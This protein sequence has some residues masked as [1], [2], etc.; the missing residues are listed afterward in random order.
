MYGARTNRRCRLHLAYFTQGSQRPENRPVD[1]ES[2]E[3]QKQGRFVIMDRKNRIRGV[4]SKNERG[5]FSM[6][7]DPEKKIKAPSMSAFPEALSLKLSSASAS[8]SLSAIPMRRFKDIL[9]LFAPVKDI[10]KCLVDGLC[11]DHPD[12]SRASMDKKVRGWLNGKN[13]PTARQDL[14]ELC[15]ILGLSTGEADSFLAMTSEEGIHWRNPTDLTLAFALRNKMN[16]PE[17]QALLDRVIPEEDTLGKESYRETF[18][19]TV[20]REAAL[21]VTEEELARYLKETQSKL[22]IYHNR[23]YQQFMAFLSLLENP[24]SVGAA[25]ES[26]TVR[27]IMETYLGGQLPAGMK[28]KRMDEKRHRILAGWPDEVTISRMKTGRM[29]VN[30]KTMM[31]LFLVTDGGEGA[32]GGWK[33]EEETDPDADFRSS[34]IRMNQMLSSCGYCM[35]DLRNPFDWMIVYC[36]KSAS[37]PAAMEGQSEQLYAML[38]T[39]FSA[40]SETK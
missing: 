17:A 6:P 34:Y 30:R 27:R 32:S 11:S 31:L 23:A 8:A 37:D 38:E 16:F 2:L 12:T 10:R 18:T 33:D 22:G 14:W 28:K 9:G 21:L 29:D 39:L 26:Y 20:Q 25:E 7:A 40:D 5:L 15:F 36:M 1:S 19:P 3:L 13:Q 4:V 24:R 35:L